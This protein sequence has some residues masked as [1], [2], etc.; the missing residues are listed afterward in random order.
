M[1]L[2]VESPLQAHRKKLVGDAFAPP[3][4]RVCRARAQRTNS[5]SCVA[6]FIDQASAVVA[7]DSQARLTIVDQRQGSAKGC[8]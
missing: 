1:I 7:R 6:R 5:P 3:T 2:G 4:E 8:L